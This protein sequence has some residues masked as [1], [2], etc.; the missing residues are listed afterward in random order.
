MG[1]K[2]RYIKLTE[3]E[4]AALEAAHKKG[5]TH[6]Y[7]TRCHC[8]LLSNEAWKMEELS[9]FFK[10][11]RRT[12]SAWMTRYETEGLKGLE[13]RDGRGRKLKLNIENP[14]HVELVKKSLKKECRGIK[15]LRQDVEEQLNTSIGATTLRDFLK[16][17][18]T[19]SDDSGT[20]SN[21]NRIQGRWVKK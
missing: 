20:A 15:Q 9:D 2:H 12:I 10:V 7:R 17:L 18:V 3:P 13:I 21:P 1:R 8:I 5:E 14:S 11:N 19:D 4:R 6:D 16:A